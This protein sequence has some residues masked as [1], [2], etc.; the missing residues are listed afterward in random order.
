MTWL[1]IL[2]YVVLALSGFVYV[3]ALFR[4]FSL[5]WYFQN[6]LPDCERDCIK[7]FPRY[8]LFYYKMRP[9]PWNK[10]IAE[11]VVRR[12]EILMKYDREKAEQLILAEKQIFFSFGPFAFT[13]VIAVFSVLR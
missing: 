4:Y 9:S 1:I 11:G 8:P 12:N 6:I 10:R 2:N 5:T 13:T 3:R 7:F